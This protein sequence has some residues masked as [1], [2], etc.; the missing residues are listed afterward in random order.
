[1]TVKSCLPLQI[2]VIEKLNHLAELRVLNLAGNM[3]T[4]VNGLTGMDSLA[5]LNLRRNK[6]KSVVSVSKGWSCMISLPF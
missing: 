2:T 5:E 4:H 1:M 6:I 3:I